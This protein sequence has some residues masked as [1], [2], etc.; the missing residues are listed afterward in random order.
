MLIE[1]TAKLWVSHRKVTVSSCDEIIVNGP[2]A[3]DQCIEILLRTSN[4]G[5]DGSSISLLVHIIKCPGGDGRARHGNHLVEQTLQC[6][7]IKENYCF[8][9]IDIYLHWPRLKDWA[10]WHLCPR[11]IGQILWLC[12]DRLQ[13]A[14]WSRGSI[15]DQQSGQGGLGCQG[16]PLCQDTWS[17]GK[18]KIY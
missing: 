10:G 18:V 2:H 6:L 17:L 16:S 14:W 13:S 3:V 1:S 7:D 5:G 8:Y 15:P 4:L 12:P 9:M 11:Q